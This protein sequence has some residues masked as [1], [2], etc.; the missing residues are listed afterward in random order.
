MPGVEVVLFATG[1]STCPVP[2]RWHHPRA[3]GTEY[4]PAP[5]LAHVEAAYRALSDVDV[6]HDHTLLGPHWARKHRVA[7][8]VVSTVHGAFLPRL[9]AHYARLHREGVHIV[10]IS[11]AQARAAPPGVVERVIHHGLDPARYTVGSGDGYVAFL[12]RMCEDKGPHRAVLAARRAGVPIR[13]AAKVQLPEERRFFDESVAPL[14]G[15]DATFL[16]EVDHQ[17]K[18]VLLQGATALVNPIR[19][20]EPFG[21]VMIE[22]MLCGTPVIAFPEGAATE[23][24]EDGVTGFLRHDVAGLADAIGAAKGL[25]RAICRAR[26]IERF[27]SGRMVAQHLDLYR[28]VLGATGGSGPAPGGAVGRAA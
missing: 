17:A 21:L 5:E 20:D 23:V 9:A 12:G 7:A 26:A 25:D 15:P 10:A 16:G 3:L 4:R 22:A 18:V 24:V 13:L 27:S 28:A 1:D 14:L 6:V 2:R 8:P 19:W 11:H